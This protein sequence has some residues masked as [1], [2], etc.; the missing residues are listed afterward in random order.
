MVCRVST[1]HC[2][3]CKCL[4]VTTV[5]SE[6]WAWVILCLHGPSL[7]YFPLYS[8]PRPVGGHWPCMWGRNEIFPTISTVFRAALHNLLHF[9]SPIVCRVQRTIY[10]IQIVSN[11]QCTVITAQ[12]SGWNMPLVFLS[13]GSTGRACQPLYYNTSNCLMF[14]PWN[15][16]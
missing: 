13:D 4:A 1:A 15:T 9:P 7:L 2:W 16:T 6:L 8:W 11:V 14:L 3:R 12:C 5:S 10:N